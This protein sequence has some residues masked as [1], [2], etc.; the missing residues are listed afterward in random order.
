[1]P[2]ID[3]SKPISEI[4]NNKRTQGEKA[5][6]GER[7]IN[8]EKNILIHTMPK[9]FKVS[10]DGNIS[11]KTKVVGAV[12]MVVGAFVLIALVY[13]SYIYLIKAP[14]ESRQP[15][16]QAEEIEKIVEEVE[17]L[18]E[19][20][21]KIIE[22][23][24]GEELIE[25]EE[26]ELI[27]EIA[28]TTEEEMAEG[29][30]KDSDS[31]GLS[32][33]EEI[34]FGS[35]ITLADSDEDGYPDKAEVG[36]LYNPA[37]TGQLL[38]NPGISQYQNSAFNYSILYVDEWMKQ[39]VGDGST[40]IFGADDGSF[41]QIISQA[42]DGNKTIGNW[43]GDQFPERRIVTDDVVEKNSW[44]GIFHENK[45]IFYLT[46]EERNNIFIISYVP[47]PENSL[48]YYNIFRIAIDSFQIGDSE[49]SH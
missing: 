35:S 38:D 10:A 36:N 19:E 8:V 30:F 27:E 22:E 45:K 43:F 40:A 12:I 16:D 28:T 41:V 25:E 21:E 15:E 6:R 5:E 39:V 11:G 24:E 23:A 34:I 48:S 18:E 31:D 4:G 17:I 32:D 2:E 42:N 37:G 1:M 13:L 7:S 49:E 3:D 20:A 26:E 33:L 46:G 14:S 9:K 44:Q 47:E 29:I